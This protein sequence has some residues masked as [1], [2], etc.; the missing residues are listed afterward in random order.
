MSH[1]D[2]PRCPTSGKVC[3]TEAEAKAARRG[4]Q[5]FNVGRMEKYKCPDRHLHDDRPWHIGHALGP[6]ARKRRKRG[7][8]IGALGGD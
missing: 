2:K 3:Y 6:K 7:P 1:D 8:V 5:R 4:A